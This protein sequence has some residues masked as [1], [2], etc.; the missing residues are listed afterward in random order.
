MPVLTAHSVTKAYGLRPLFDQATFT[1][2]RGEKVA[3]LGPNGTGKTPAPIVPVVV[4]GGPHKGR[5]GDYDDDD[6]DDRDRPAAV[7]YFGDMFQVAPELVAY[8]KLREV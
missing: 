7:V 8:S 2:R 5:I 6:A 4:T 3:L 1:I